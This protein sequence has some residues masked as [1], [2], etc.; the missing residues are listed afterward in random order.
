MTAEEIAELVS[1]LRD[2]AEAAEPQFMTVPEY[3]AYLRLD[4]MDVKDPGRWIRERLKPSHPEFLAHHRFT[5]NNPVF[6]RDDRAVN[7]ERYRKAESARTRPTAPQADAQI[8]E[9]EKA[10][11][12]GGRALGLGTNRTTA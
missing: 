7:S 6:S 10:A 5:R 11:K 3:A 9:F 4:E 1:A 2:A 8:L 12:R